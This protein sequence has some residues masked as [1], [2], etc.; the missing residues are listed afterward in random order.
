MRAKVNWTDISL[1]VFFLLIG[2]YLTVSASVL[3]AASG[4]LAGP[5]FFPRAIGVVMLGLGTILL[6]QGIRARS[7]A[8]FD[9]RHGGTIAAI[10]ILTAL[11]LLLWGIGFFPLR[12]FIFVVLFLRLLGESWKTGVGVSLVLTAA[13][14]GAFQYGLRLSL[15]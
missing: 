8:S 11:Y 1:A 7:T 5:G 15:D 3:P 14:T 10:V 12:T 4:G 13:V 9:V 6:F 2:I